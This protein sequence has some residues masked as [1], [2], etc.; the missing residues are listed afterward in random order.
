MELTVKAMSAKFG[1]DG[2][3]HILV[4][5]VFE[6]LIGRLGELALTQERSGHILVTS[7]DGPTLP[8]NCFTVLHSS[9]SLRR[10]GLRTGWISCDPERGLSKWVM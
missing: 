7:R 4:E 6:G 1:V 10:V 5:I 3:N 9:P 2:C 8:T